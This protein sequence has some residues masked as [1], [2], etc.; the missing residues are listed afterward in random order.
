MLPRC[1]RRTAR[2]FRRGAV[3]RNDF[4]VHTRRIQ[5]EIRGIHSPEF[6]KIPHPV[7]GV[8]AW[9][10]VGRY[11]NVRL[12]TSGAFATHCVGITDGAYAIVEIRWAGETVGLVEVV[13]RQEL[14]AIA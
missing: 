12:A 3:S 7:E 2:R 5:L 6:G 14:G 8:D 10:C 4:H 1:R 11:G 9:F 13:E